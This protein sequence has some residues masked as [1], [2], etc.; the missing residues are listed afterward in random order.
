MI[1]LKEISFLIASIIDTFQTKRAV[2]AI[3]DEREEMSGNASEE[4]F[5]KSGEL[6]EFFIKSEIL[7]ENYEGCFVKN[8][9]LT[10]NF[11]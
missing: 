8:E 4:G 2:N 9:K 10:K 3:D 6:M 11:S 5:V 1:N 7:G